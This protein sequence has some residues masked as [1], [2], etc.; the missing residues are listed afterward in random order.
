MAKN[1][2][3]RH[4]QMNLNRINNLLDQIIEKAKQD[5]VKF[6]EENVCG[7]AQQTVG[8]SWMVFHLKNLKQLIKAE[9]E[10]KLP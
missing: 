9:S 6:R 3:G 2:T 5:D 8:E 1:I 7:N 10:K 4:H